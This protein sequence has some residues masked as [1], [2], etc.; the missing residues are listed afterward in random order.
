MYRVHV[1]QPSG[2]S[3]KHF[4]TTTR[5]LPGNAHILIKELH[6]VSALV[7]CKSVANSSQA[8]KRGNH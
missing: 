2:K 8:Q 6:A 3:I 7:N 5:G 4:E 1:H